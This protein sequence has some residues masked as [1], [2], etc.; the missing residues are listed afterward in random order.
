MVRWRVGIDYFPFFLAADFFA[1]GAFFAAD[2]LA[3]FFAGVFF[4]AAFF[5][6]GAFAAVF[7]AVFAGRDSNVS[8]FSF[9]SGSRPLPSAADSIRTTSDHRMWYVD[10]SEYGITCTVGM[11]RPDRK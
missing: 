8:T 3:A 6:A 9:A 5:A 11:L 1:A 4:A 2:F 7:A 10:T